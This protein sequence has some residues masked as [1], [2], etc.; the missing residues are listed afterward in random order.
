MQNGRVLL[1]SLYFEPLIKS[2]WL[3][4]PTSAKQLFFHEAACKVCNI[5]ETQCSSDAWE[6]LS[7]RFVIWWIFMFLCCVGTINCTACTCHETRCFFVAWEQ[8][9]VDCVT[10]MQAVV[11]L[12]RE[13]LTVGFVIGMKLVVFSAAG[14]QIAVGL[15]IG[16]ENIV[17]V[18]RGNN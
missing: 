1:G 8:N 6:Q 9:N 2:E 14:E 17:F 4:V 10:E 16:M 18:L 12:L 7:L 5:H 3:H 13:Q 15:V 11:F